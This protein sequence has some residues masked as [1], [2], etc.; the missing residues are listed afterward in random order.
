[1]HYL[2]GYVMQATV[3]TALAFC[4]L[5]HGSVLHNIVLRTH[6]RLCFCNTRRNSQGFVTAESAEVSNRDKN[7]GWETWAILKKNASKHQPEKK[8]AWGHSIKSL[9]LK[10]VKRVSSNFFFPSLLP[11][12]FWLCQ[13]LS[14]VMSVSLPFRL[15]HLSIQESSCW[16]SCTPY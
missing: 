5:T 8:Q 12:I 2:H 9:M 13:R 10:S 11:I 3:Q 7:R 6:N 16:N 14:V 15:G 1:M 4:C